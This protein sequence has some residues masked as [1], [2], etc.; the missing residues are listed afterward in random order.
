MMPLGAFL[1]PSFLNFMPM[2]A[3]D[4]AR[5]PNFP[6]VA[7]AVFPLGGM[8]ASQ[9]AWRTSILA[10]LW[11]GYKVHLTET[12]DDETP[13]LIT[14]V[15]TTPATIYDGAVLETI[16]AALAEKGLRPQWSGDH[17]NRCDSFTMIPRSQVWIGRMY[18]V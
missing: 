6:A 16:H 9:S 18:V 8:M 14:H 5:S 11:A 15:E 13:H 3:A 4:G 17:W 12:C 2:G 10:I 7:C 1:C